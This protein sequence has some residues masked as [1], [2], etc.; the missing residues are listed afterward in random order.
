MPVHIKD[1]KSLPS[2]IR[3]ELQTQNHWILSKTNNNF[4]AIPIDQAH[5][6]E[7]V[8]VKGAGGF[9]GLTENPTAFRRWMLSGLELAR[10]QRQFEDKY[11]SDNNPDNPR[12]FRNHEQGLATQKT[13]QKQVNTL[14]SAIERMGNPF[15][16]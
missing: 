9:I 13:F 11:F 16:G 4:S 3:N 7:N 8:F 5:E 1:M 12:N 14:F 2:S 6:Q 15:S 10:I